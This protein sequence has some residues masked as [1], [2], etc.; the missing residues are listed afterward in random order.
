MAIY[1]TAHLPFLVLAVTSS[2]VQYIAHD[3]MASRGHLDTDLVL[4]TRVQL[5]VQQ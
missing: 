4:A 3:R 5:N 2:P 1:M